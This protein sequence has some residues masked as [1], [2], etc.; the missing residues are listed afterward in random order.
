MF[1]P[2]HYLLIKRKKSKIRRLG[3]EFDQD[4]EMY[5][6][7]TTTKLKVRLGSNGLALP[8]ACTTSTL[9]RLMFVMKL[10][11]LALALNLP[12]F[13]RLTASFTGL[14]SG[15]MSRGLCDS[16]IKSISTCSQSWA[17]FFQN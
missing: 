7:R 11:I 5:P 15:A 9:M 1:C 14:L 8:L 12:F 13:I 3:Q 10:F 17:H 2:I 6:K 16:F 4:Q